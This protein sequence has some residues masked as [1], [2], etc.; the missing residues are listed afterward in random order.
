MNPSIFDFVRDMLLL[1]YRENAD[2][3]ERERSAAS[4]ASFSS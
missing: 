2:E 4:W 1:R 3:G